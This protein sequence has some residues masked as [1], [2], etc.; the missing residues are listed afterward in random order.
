MNFNR[1]KNVGTPKHNEDATPRSYV[2]NMVKAVEEKL[3]KR[4][5]L[6]T[7]TA[8]FHGDLIKGKYQFI[9]GGPNSPTY[10]KHD[11]FNGFLMSH[12][13]YIKRFVLENFGVK[14]D[15]KLLTNLQNIPIPLFTLVLI[16][17]GSIDIIDLGTYNIIFRYDR[18]GDLKTV[19]SFISNVG[20]LNKYH[21]SK[22]DIIN[23]RTEYNAY[24]GE[25]NYP[26]NERGYKIKI[27]EE[28]YVNLVS[29]LIELDPLED[30]DD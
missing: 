13:G 23:V 22:K 17:N 4:K 27:K 26:F 28:F 5:Q 8:S 30:E 7:A 11:A 21:L 2:E 24:I 20:D 16:K 14:F 19:Y 25:N 18:L 15:T 10:D 3:K 29:V 1:I 6:I 9:F 12:S